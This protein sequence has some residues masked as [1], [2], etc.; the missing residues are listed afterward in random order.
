MPLL[1]N[2][3]GDGRRSL[4]WYGIQ[5]YDQLQAMEVEARQ[6][7]RQ[8]FP[9]FPGILN[10]HEELTERRHELVFGEN[11]QL[12]ISRIERIRGRLSDVLMQASSVVAP[13]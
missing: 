10:L 11:G 3:V 8:Q 5:S 6:R 2:I 1:V 7:L 4:G 9:E 13:K 12:R